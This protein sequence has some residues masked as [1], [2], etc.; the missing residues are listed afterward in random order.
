MPVM[1]PALT[2][3][4]AGVTAAA[5]NV[6][7]VWN[8]AV[9]VS[10]ASASASSTNYV[11]ATWN[12]ATATTVTNVW[13]TWNGVVEETREQRQVRERR[14]AEFVEEQRKQAS[15]AAAARA[16]AARLLEANLDEE[17]RKTLVEKNCFYLHTKAGRKYRIDRGTHGNVKLIDETGKILKGYCAQ[18]DGVPVEDSMLAQ[19]LMLESDEDAFLRVANARPY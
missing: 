12:A 3:S 5:S 10:T 15:E 14:Q 16:R 17:Q 11:W 8:T 18:P 2:G 6:W 7:V 9:T 13:G 4:G 19:K 1:G